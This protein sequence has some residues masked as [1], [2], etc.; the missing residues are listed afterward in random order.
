MERVLCSATVDT[1]KPS[2]PKTIGVF[3]VFVWGKAPHDQQRTYE[4]KA[5]NENVAAQEGISRFV[6]EMQ[7]S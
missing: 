4:I 2:T 3:K 7:G 1:V 6:K 5:R